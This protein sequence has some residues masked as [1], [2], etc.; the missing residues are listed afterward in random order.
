MSHVRG[1][2]VKHTS[3]NRSTPPSCIRAAALWAFL[4]LTGCQTPS[5]RIASMTE[6]ERIELAH[7]LAYRAS[8]QDDPIDAQRHYLNAIDAHGSFAPAW[9]NLAVLL[10]ESN[11]LMEADEAL[12]IAASIDRADPRPVYNRGLI[13]QRLG[14][15][16][17]AIDFYDQ[18]LERDPNFL[19]ALVGHIECEVIEQITNETTLA[20]I[21]RALRLD[22]NDKRIRTLKLQQQRIEEDLRAAER[23]VSEFRGVLGR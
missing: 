14:Q 4:A 19:P 10:L 5:D 8:Q 6:A 20:R 22:S 9:N 12:R 11:R 1:S 2:T 18:S 21:D 3:N 23:P 17:D 7:D 16:L 15:L 13:R